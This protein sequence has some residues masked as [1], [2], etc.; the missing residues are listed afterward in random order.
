MGPLLFILYVNNMPRLLNHS[1]IAIYADD[2]VIYTSGN[3][4]DEITFKLQTDLN[5]LLSWLCA[6]KLSINAKKC[7]SLV[8]S[9]PQHRTRTEQ[10]RLFV[11]NNELEQVKVY[12]YLGV[13]LDETLNFHHH[14]NVTCSKINKRIGMI[15]VARKFLDLDTT[16]L[17]YKSLVL[18]VFDYADI[19]YMH[20]S[21]ENLNSLQVLQNNFCRIMLR[22]PRLTPTVHLHNT[23][24]L[25]ILSRRRHFHYCI[26]VYKCLNG[27]L[28][29]YLADRLKLQDVQYVHQTRAVTR[30]DLII[31]ATHLM[32]TRCA[33]SYVGPLI[34]N[35]LLE[36]TREA[37]SVATF[38]SSYL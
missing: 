19:I 11:G 32:I 14:I 24:K 34:W 12:K 37:P 22:A 9:T 31:P 3:T 26:Y 30:N 33:F 10:L 2:T 29:Q 38:K 1:R 6:N 7:K 23:L 5:R 18:S 35:C 17:L 36:Q 20:T 25:M 27:K 21:L 13:W 15:K 28:P 4:M 8:I 16:L